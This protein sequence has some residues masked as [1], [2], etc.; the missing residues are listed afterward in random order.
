MLDR[1]FRGLDGVLRA[2]FEHLGARF[3][4]H[5]L[6]LVDRRGAVD[7]ARDEQGFFALF[8]EKIGKFPAQRGL[9]RA[10]QAAHHDDCRRFV[11]NFQFGVGGTHQ[12]AQL[13]VDDLDDLLRGI[14]TLQDLLPHRLFRNVCDEFFGDENVDVRFQKR[15]AHFPHRPFDL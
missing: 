4:A 11:G 10:L 7:V 6:Q 9:A 2:L 8:F 15:D 1:L 3:A 13:V 5:D 12:R 14:K